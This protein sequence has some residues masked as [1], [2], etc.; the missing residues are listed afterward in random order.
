MAVLGA[1][2]LTLLDYFK[3]IDPDGK[4]ARIVELLS[5]T[6]DMIL[7]MPWLEGNLETGH[8]VTIRTG[9]PS[10]FWRLANK[11]VN[12]S[13]S[14]TA[15]VT[16]ATG[17]LE[18]WSEVA[19]EIAKLGGN[20]NQTRLSEG[21]AFLEAMNQEF[22]RTLIF[23]N[24]AIDPEQITGFANR[25]S[26]LSAENGQN[27]VDGGGVGS[28]NSSIWLICW[29]EMSVYGIYPKGSQAG[30]IHEDFGLVTIQGANGIATE[31]MRGY[32]E[33][34]QWNP[35]LVV[36]DWRQTVRIPNI[37]ISNLVAESSAADLNKL[38]IKASHRIQAPRMG[39]C[40][41][42]MNRTVFQMLDIQSRN[43]VRTG[44]QLRY[45]E[46]DGQEIAFFRTWPIRIVDQLTESE[47][48]VT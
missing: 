8:K 42:Y 27:I 25:Y 24:S 22:Q 46:V 16:E 44:G 30:L 14:R 23:G 48:Q 12:P 3:R 26:S 19:E 47:G 2:A 15:Q 39:R 7:D 43:D 6:N 36:K 13:K 29:G 5:Q 33:R 40:V 32:Q 20:V 31:R 4:L 28:D 41:W 9:L 10:V 11:G 18:A 1:N 35:G 21:M 45:V 17:I 34:W 37:D 38:M